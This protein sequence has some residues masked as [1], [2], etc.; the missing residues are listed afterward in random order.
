MPADPTT[1]AAASAAAGL[2]T[3]TVAMIGVEPRDILWVAVGASIGIT[4]T[5][6]M[7]RG[8]AVAVFIAT[9]LAGALLSRILA[10]HWFGGDPMWRN[11]IALIMGMTFPIV[12]TWLMA[13]VPS[14]LDT[15]LRL[16]GGPSKGGEQ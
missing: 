16:R 11:G 10:H 12:K 14:V 8:R 7:S 6:P 9:T 5:E 3:V 2:A 1:A 13:A 15:L 4:S